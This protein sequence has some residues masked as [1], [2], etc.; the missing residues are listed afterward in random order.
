MKM[1]AVLLIALLGLESEAQARL[2]ETPA[3]AAARFGTCINSTT[4]KS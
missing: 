3:Q 4:I 1:I 2:G